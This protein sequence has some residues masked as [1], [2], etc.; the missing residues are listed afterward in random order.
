MVVGMKGIG[1]EERFTGLEMS[2]DPMDL[3]GTM[4]DGSR[5]C[6]FGPSRVITTPKSTNNI[7]LRTAAT[8]PLELPLT[9]ILFVGEDESTCYSRQIPNIPPLLRGEA[10]RQ[11]QDTPKMHQKEITGGSNDGGLLP[12]LLAA[13]DDTED[14]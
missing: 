6:Q 1:R 7:F 4:V 10:Y 11:W 2:I 5:G 13:V 3:C 8:R 9:M 12:L 14:W